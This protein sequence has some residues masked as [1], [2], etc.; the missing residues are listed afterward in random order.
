MVPVV[1]QPKHMF[2]VPVLIYIIP[3]AA[4]TDLPVTRRFPPSVGVP[5]EMLVPFRL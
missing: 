5:G 1:S 2:L 4:N 3:N